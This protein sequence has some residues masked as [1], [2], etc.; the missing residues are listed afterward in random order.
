[1]QQ[2]EILVLILWILIVLAQVPQIIGIVEILKLGGVAPEFFV[3]G[4]DGARVLHSAVNHFLFPVAPDLK[5]NFG[6][7]SGGRDCH[8]RDH[9]H[10]RKQNVTIFT[11]A[12]PAL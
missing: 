9:E 12:K 11:P 6:K 8:Q 7:H 10:Q 2:F 4:S 1:M 3:V 5:R